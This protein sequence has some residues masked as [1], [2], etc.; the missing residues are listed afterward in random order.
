MD[1]R[2]LMTFVNFVVD[3]W[4]RNKPELHNLRDDLQSEGY[5]RALEARD[6]WDPKRTKDLRLHL[7]YQVRFAI[8]DYVRDKEVKHFKK[9]PV[10]HEDP[11]WDIG[12]PVEVEDIRSQDP[13]EDTKR[14]LMEALTGVSLSPREQEFLGHYL[15]G[16][17]VKGASA[18]MGIGQ[19]RGNQL[20]Q[21]IVAKAK[22]CNDVP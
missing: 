3:K 18:L 2:D 1:T 17:T 8:R 21:S 20:L 7:D 6:A 10:D 15:S 14:E 16:L 4:L 13:R 11:Y 22:K 5:L 19:P 12:E 9:K